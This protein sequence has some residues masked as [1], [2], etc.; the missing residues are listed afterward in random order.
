MLNQVGVSTPKAERLVI[1]LS[2]YFL[3]VGLTERSLKGF[4]PFAGRL[5]TKD[6]WVSE[7]GDGKGLRVV[8]TPA[9]GREALEY[10][11]SIIDNPTCFLKPFEPHVTIRVDLA[12]LA[13]TVRS[14]PS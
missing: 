14:E 5:E 11:W 13:R 7:I 4:N 9:G 12:K 6:G 1:H 8:H 10:G 2:M 3:G